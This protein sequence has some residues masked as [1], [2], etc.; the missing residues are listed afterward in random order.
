MIASTPS[1]ITISKKQP[2]VLDR[3]WTELDIREEII[4]HCPACAEKY[5]QLKKSYSLKGAI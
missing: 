3:I 1:D 4:L 5:T 2:D